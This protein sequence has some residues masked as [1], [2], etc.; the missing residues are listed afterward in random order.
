MRG[1][2]DPPRAEEAGLQLRPSE[3]SPWDLGAQSSPYGQGRKCI[4]N[5]LILWPHRAPGWRQGRG[6]PSR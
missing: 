5:L 1:Q 4:P 2:V 3:S 6:R